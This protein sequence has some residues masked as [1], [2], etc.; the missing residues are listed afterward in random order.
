MAQNC[1]PFTGKELDSE[2]GYSYFGARYYDAELSGLFFSVDPMVDKYPSISP[3]AYCMWN[4]IGII[5]PLGMDTIFSYATNSTDAEQN[6]KNAEILKWMREEGD[7]P[8]MV[9]LSMHGSS[10]QVEI[11]ICDG[12]VTTNC[13]AVNLANMIKGTF[14]PDYEHNKETGCNTIFLLYSCYTGKGGNSIAEQL[15]WE[16]QEITIAP[17]GTLLVRNS[18]H[19]MTNTTSNTDMTVQPWI[20]YYRGRKVLDFEGLSPKE[21]ITNM[22]GLNSVVEYIKEKDRRSHPWE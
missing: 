4:P 15:S 8:G 19:T 21:W 3:F 20:V 5:D 10:F 9:T 7:T 6:N 17:Q 22:G 13:D 2:T 18:D 11:S 12:F 16:L 1:I 14:L